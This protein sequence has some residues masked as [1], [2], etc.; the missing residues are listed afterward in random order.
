MVYQRFG[1]TTE[2]ELFGNANSG[3]AFDEF[4][5]VLGERV[6]LKDFDGYRGGLDIQHGQTGAESVY[7]Q[8]RQKEIMFHVSTL[9]PFTVGDTQQLQRK[10]HIGNDIVTV[11]FQV[12][13]GGF[14]V[15]IS[16]TRF[17]FFGILNL[18]Y[19]ISLVCFEFFRF[20]TYSKGFP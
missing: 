5:E 17:D 1:Q 4:L 10:R 11:V 7:T 18:F 19:G 9:L 20:L 3:R 2:E 12:S 8:F 6:P 14:L 15:R 16:L 13:V